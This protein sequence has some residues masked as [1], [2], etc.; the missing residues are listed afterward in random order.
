MRTQRR[1]APRFRGTALTSVPHRGWTWTRRPVQEPA[2]G[3]R[4][5]APGKAKQAGRVAAG[6][7]RH[8]CLLL[9]T[10]DMT[11]SVR[12]V[13]LAR[14]GGTCARHPYKTRSRCLAVARRLFLRK[15]APPHSLPACWRARGAAAW[16]VSGRSRSPRSCVRASWD[17]RGPRGLT[18]SSE[19]L[20]C[21]G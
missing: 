11:M 20:E 17:V 9:P 5:S 15:E 16:P 4:D 6:R 1:S 8:D 2:G 14:F 3:P 18:P 12:G 19:F 10:S 13:T 7:R 21:T